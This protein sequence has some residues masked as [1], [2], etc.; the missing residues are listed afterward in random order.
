LVS[1][2]YLW[3]NI[4]KETKMETKKWYKSKGV[5][6]SLVGI[7]TMVV[8]LAMKVFGVD[9]EAEQASIT[10]IVA[11]IIALVGMITALVGRIKA[12]KKVTL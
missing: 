6:G 12:D 8:M 5:D 10:E 3:Y 4:F 7:I 9:A 11:V 2:P 1:G